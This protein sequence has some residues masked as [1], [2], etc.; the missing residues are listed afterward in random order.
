MSGSK[1]KHEKLNESE[2]L[3]SNSKFK[4]QLISSRHRVNR[5]RASSTTTGAG[6]CNERKLSGKANEEG[7]QWFLNVISV[8]VDLAVSMLTIIRR[9]VKRDVSIT[10][11]SSVKVVGL[12]FN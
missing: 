11:T 1:M 3:E 5:S 10:L 2:A 9:D 8:D 6:S 4:F 7:D 12:T